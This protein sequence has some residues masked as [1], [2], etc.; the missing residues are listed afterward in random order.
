[1]TEQERER[2]IELCQKIIN[3]EK[4]DPQDTIP[5]LRELNKILNERD[6]RVGRTPPPDS[7]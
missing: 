3:S 1:M 5:L 7:A 2:V 6:R 4:L